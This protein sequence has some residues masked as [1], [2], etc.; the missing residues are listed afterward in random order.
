MTV[1]VFRVDSGTSA[2]VHDGDGFVN[3]AVVGDCGILGMKGQD[4]SE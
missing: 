2:V 4:V 3:G 1:F